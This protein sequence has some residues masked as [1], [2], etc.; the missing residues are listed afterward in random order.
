MT[1][2]EFQVAQD[3]LTTQLNK[4]LQE[5]ITELGNVDNVPQALVDKLAAA[6][7]VAQQLDDL[8]PDPPQQ[9]TPEPTKG[10]DETK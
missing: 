2:E 5:I 4:A 8:N 10:G 6:K 7:A 9:Q 1:F 3:A